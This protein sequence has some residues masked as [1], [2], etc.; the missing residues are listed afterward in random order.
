MAAELH[1]LE[2]MEESVRQLGDVERV[3]GV[4][5]AQ[6]ES[7]SLAQMLKARQLAHARDLYELKIKAEREA[8]Q[9]QE[10]LA[11][12]QK[13]TLEGLQEAAKEMM[14]HQAEAARYTADT[15]R[16]IRE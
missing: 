12:N 15:A 8:H 13:D 3:M 1:H 5:M 6:Q 4:S 10:N 11:S 2:T 7:V 16:H 9:L 14:S